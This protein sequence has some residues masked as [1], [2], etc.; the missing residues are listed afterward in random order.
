MKYFCI[1]GV[2]LAGVAI[3]YLI[4]DYWDRLPVLGDVEKPQIIEKISDDDGENQSTEASGGS[5]VSAFR[6][7]IPLRD[8]PLTDS[9]K[10]TAETFGID[11]E[12]FVITS[13]ML[14]CAEGK[15]GEARLN[16]VIAGDSP[17]FGESLSLMACLSAD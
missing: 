3:G 5:N 9:Q 17:T 6:E 10:K 15:L 1:F 13:A 8:L 11:A 14:V 4:C 7:P 12:T 16:A 2:L